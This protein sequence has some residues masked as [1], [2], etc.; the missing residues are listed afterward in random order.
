MH[1]PSEIH[2]LYH[3][4]P[5]HPQISGNSPVTTVVANS[6]GTIEHILEGLNTPEQVKT[7]LSKR[8]SILNQQAGS[9]YLTMPSK[10]DPGAIIVDPESELKPYINT[11]RMEESVCVCVCVCV[12]THMCLYVCVCVCVRESGVCI[13]HVH[14]CVYVCEWG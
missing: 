14:V 7:F 12:R 9:G 6:D 13:Q 2:L 3:A 5:S 11:G 10:G 1:L 4:S 8:Y